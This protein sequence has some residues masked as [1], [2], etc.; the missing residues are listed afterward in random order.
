M[1]QI[2]KL[3]MFFP[4]LIMMVFCITG[5]QMTDQASAKTSVDY[6]Y[7]SQ[8][9]LKSTIENQSPVVILDVQVEE[10]FDAHHIEGAIATY[11]F[12]VKSD[13]DKA[14]IDAQLQFLEAS[15]GDIVI[16]CP[17]GRVGAERTYEHLI[18]QGID[19][20]RLFILEGGQAGWT[21]PIDTTVDTDDT[22]N[23]DDTE[24]TDSIESTPES[25]ESDDT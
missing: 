1:K 22:V 5:C 17:K 10:D 15:D 24:A 20:E 23:T 11:A 9:Q 8:S 4:I 21:S 12:P 18:E 14:K 7:Y 16:I 13:E 6:N 2:K 3:S 25:D 19:S